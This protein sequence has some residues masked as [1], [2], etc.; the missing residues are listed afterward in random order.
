MSGAAT[1]AQIAAFAALRARV[2]ARR[3]IAGLVEAML[4]HAPGS[5]AAEV[6]SGAVDVVGTGGDGP[7][8]Q[9]FDHGGAGRGRL[10][11]CRWSSTATA[12]P[13]PPPGRADLLEAL[14]MRWTWA[15]GGG[16]VRGRGRHRVL[17]RPDLPPG[18][19]LRRPGPQRVRGADRLQYPRSADQP[20]LARPPARSA[21][22]I[23][24]MAPVMAQVFAD[25]GSR[26]CS[27]G[28]RTAWTSSPPRH[29]PGSGSPLA[30]Q[31]NRDRDR[32]G[33]PGAAA[34]HH[35]GAARRRPRVKRRGAA[36]PARR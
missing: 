24:R 33:R 16:A 22:P 14:G 31:V 7:S 35:R 5:R 19:P 18:L 1:A 32:R 20:G 9:H 27:P 11:G 10:P 4:A 34:H 23:A 25:R 2:K 30:A 13:P 8:G 26:C 15:G 6:R 29:P 12:P 17:L 3:E 36:A 21:A 28:G